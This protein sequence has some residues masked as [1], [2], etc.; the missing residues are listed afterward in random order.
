[1]KK[2][3][4]RDTDTLV[5]KRPFLPL[6]PSFPSSGKDNVLGWMTSSSHLCDL[7][8]EQYIQPN[9]LRCFCYLYSLFPS[10]SRREYWNFLRILLLQR[11]PQNIPVALMSVGRPLRI[12]NFSYYWNGL[13]NY[14]NGSIVNDSLQNWGERRKLASRRVTLWGFFLSCII[15]FLY[16]E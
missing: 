6:T 15:I 11:S 3:V 8:P 2:R 1:M 4:M 9:G 13:L 10:E 5:C 14:W 12:Q 7:I 16:G